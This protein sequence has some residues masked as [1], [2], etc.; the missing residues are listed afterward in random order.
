MFHKRNKV[1]DED[2]EF[3]KMLSTNSPAFRKSVLRFPEFDVA[4]CGVALLPSPY[5]TPAAD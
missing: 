2:N 1:R 3:K 5:T 4:K